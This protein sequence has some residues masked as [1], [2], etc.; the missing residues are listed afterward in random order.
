VGYALS[1]T[2]ILKSSARQTS[3]L[4][5]AMA[6]VCLP[7]LA[8]YPLPADGPRS[9]QGGRPSPSAAS[10]PC[11]FR[12]LNTYHADAVRMKTSH[13][14]SGQPYLPWVRNDTFVERVY[15]SAESEQKLYMH[16][17]NAVLKTLND[18]AFED[19]EV[20][21]S[22]LNL[23]KTLFFKHLQHSPAADYLL[24][25]EEGGRYNDYKSIRLVFDVSKATPQWMVEE[26]DKLRQAVDSE[27][28]RE[29]FSFKVLSQAYEND[30]NPRV[31]NPRYW[32]EVGLGMTPE[33]AS[34]KARLR[35]HSVDKNILFDSS[36]EAKI[37]E[38]LRIAERDRLVLSEYFKGTSV[39]NQALPS[40]ALVDILRFA[41]TAPG[42]RTQA[43][44]RT[45]VQNSLQ[46]RFP[47]GEVDVD[48]IDRLQRYFNLANKL[49]PSVMTPFQEPIELADLSHAD[50]GVWAFDISGQNMRNMTA[51]FYAIHYATQAAVH[52]KA[53]DADLVDGTLQDTALHQQRQSE[54]FWKVRQILQETLVRHDVIPRNVPE[55]LQSVGDESSA[56]PYQH[57][58][59]VQ[60]A[61]ALT[62][63]AANPEYG[64][65][66]RSVLQ[67]QTYADGQ[68]IPR[69][70]RFELIAQGEK[71]EKSVRKKL[72]GSRGLG[73]F[74]Y[75]DLREVLI[76]IRITPLTKQS[77]RIDVDVARSPSF[78][79]SPRFAEILSRLREEMPVELPSGWSMGRVETTERVLDQVDASNPPAAK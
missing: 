27:F 21:A 23:Y 63:L 36:D 12:R 70:E 57:V 76:S 58:S 26:L 61:K 8:T 45:Y 47:I 18:K 33:K 11:D 72:E 28:A 66:Y 60:K 46:R 42:V 13:L 35:R 7:A 59:P 77:S 40:E 2:Q 14:Y 10:K 75:H 50:H 65:L 41:Q 73:L 1:C 4:I 32:H 52:S 17:E 34:L 25:L 48:T 38:D 56:L 78:R 54:K 39:F 71:L 20:S 6:L 37:A 31:A 69:E 67:E 79:A 22:T 29:L 64:G 19:K 51:V 68:A 44:Y 5:F 62:D 3:V 15:H 43:D 55:R 49:A 16:V 74:P 53:S 24:G 9:G 30:T